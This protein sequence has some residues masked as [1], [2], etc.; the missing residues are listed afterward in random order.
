MFNF[1]AWDWFIIFL[2][3][4]LIFGGRKIPEIARGLG[5]GIK[6]FKKAKDGLADTIES[7]ADEIKRSPEEKDK[8]KQS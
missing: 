6:E 4:L 7:E 1:Q 3:V 8:E 5:K 2:I